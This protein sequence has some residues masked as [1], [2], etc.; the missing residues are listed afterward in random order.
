M[1]FLGIIDMVVL[2]FNAI[3]GGISC[4]TGN[5]FCTNPRFNFIVGVIGTSM[6]YGGSM[7]CIIL[8]FDRFFEMCF[9]EMAKKI[10]GGRMI[11]MWLAFPI[12]YILYSF[13]EVPL[14]YN[15]VH[16]AFYFDPF[17]GSKG[18]LQE[19]QNQAV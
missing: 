7:T 11:Y 5:H 17:Y 10:F 1:F 13:N 4:V 2:P 18:N 16:H 3:I 9:P 15:V 14:V 8:A 19:P 12:I 6:W